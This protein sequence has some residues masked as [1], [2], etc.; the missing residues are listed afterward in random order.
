MAQVRILARVNR[1]EFFGRDAELRQIVR[2]ASQVSDARGLIRPRPAP[3]HQSYCARA[4]ISYSR[5]AATRSRFTLRSDDRRNGQRDRPRVLSNFLRQYIAYRRVDP[6]LADAP[7]SL[8]ELRELALPSDYEIVNGMI[9]LFEGA[10]SSD[11]DFVN[12]CFSL[13]RRFAAQGR[14]T[15]PLINCTGVLPFS[16]GAALARELF[17]ALRR[18]Q[19]SFVFAALRRQVA[20]LTH[21]ARRIVIH[22][23]SHILR[24]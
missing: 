2:Q 18:T 20:D 5:A 10:T 11:A 24:R 1:D 15:Y 4:T 3:A 12:F 9:D 8:S 21:N 23:S 14:R 19:S 22:P 16:E 6:S 7:L 17:I 13:P